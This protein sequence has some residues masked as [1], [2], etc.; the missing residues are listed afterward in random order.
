MYNSLVNFRLNNN[1]NNLL[2]NQSHSRLHN[3]NAY[4]VLKK[5]TIP[6]TERI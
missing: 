6:K 2:S 1:K 3:K 4:Y 5:L